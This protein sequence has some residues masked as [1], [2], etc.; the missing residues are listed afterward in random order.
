MTGSSVTADFIPTA[1]F[2]LKV[3]NYIYMYTS[4]IFLKYNMRVSSQATMPPFSVL[5]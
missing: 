4:Y 1:S 5:L 3:G 2:A